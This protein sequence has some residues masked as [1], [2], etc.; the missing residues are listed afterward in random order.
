MK[1][2]IECKKLLAV[3]IG[4]KERVAFPLREDHFSNSP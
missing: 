1:I 2:E 3:E 4:P